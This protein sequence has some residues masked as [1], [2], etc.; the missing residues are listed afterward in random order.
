MTRLAFAI[1]AC[2]GLLAFGPA[3]AGEKPK[4][5]PADQPKPCAVYGPDFE[6]VG[7]SGLCLRIGVSVEMGVKAS[8]HG[9]DRAVTTS[10]DWIK[11]KSAKSGS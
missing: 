10:A 2:V 5:A 11:D 4:A 8:F 7:D 9:R 1:V 6:A 3:S